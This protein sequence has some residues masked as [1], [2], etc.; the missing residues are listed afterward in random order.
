MRTR[1]HEWRTRRTGER[2]DMPDRDRGVPGP[3]PVREPSDRNVINDGTR[4]IQQRRGNRDDVRPIG[5]CEQRR[6]AAARG[7]G[8]GHVRHTPN[9]VT[10]PVRK[11]R[12]TER[13]VI[14]PKVLDHDTV[15][16][17]EHVVLPDAQRLR[18]SD[19]ERTD[20]H[21]NGLRTVE[22]PPHLPCH[23]IVHP[24]HVNPAEATV[25]V[26]NRGINGT[27]HPNSTVPGKSSSE[28]P[29]EL[30]T[31]VKDVRQGGRVM[32]R[33]VD[34]ESDRPAPRADIRHVAGLQLVTRAV[35]PPGNRA[36]RSWT[37]RAGY[38]PSRFH[39][40]ESPS[41][42]PPRRP[43]RY[44]GQNRIEQP[45]Q[46]QPKPEST[47]HRSQTLRN[48]T[49]RSLH[50]RFRGNTRRSPAPPHLGPPIPKKEIPPP[51]TSPQWQ[52]SW[53]VFSSRR[54]PTTD[55]SATAPDNPSVRRPASRGKNDPGSVHAHPI[56]DAPIKQSTH[57]EQNRVWHRTA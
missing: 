36:F 45:A 48:G 27:T 15:L 49:S 13:R 23:R 20:G 17:G 53:I 2:N 3:D 43:A 30:T 50:G 14:E 54:S 37:S 25:P 24:G 6:V 16:G 34:C 51:V 57:P 21:D 35:H 26:R 18:R 41:P 40:P 10:R 19:Q 1:K 55:T 28:D 32:R 44:L 56:N 46:E 38:A 29:P 5:R 31:A 42:A 12:R 52:G 9:G 8:T 39:A 22:I 4:R 11:K 7:D 47:R 33:S